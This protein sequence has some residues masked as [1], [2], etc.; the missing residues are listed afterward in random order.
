MNEITI[1]D[2]SMRDSIAFMQAELERLKLRGEIVCAIPEINEM[3][4]NVFIDK[5][6]PQDNWGSSWGVTFQFDKCYA[7][8]YDMCRIKFVHFDDNYMNGRQ[9][10]F[11]T[12]YNDEQLVEEFKKHVEFLK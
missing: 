10:D 1:N 6:R 7:C 4:P 5:S 9:E 3:K 2:R 11:V 12:Y 8:V